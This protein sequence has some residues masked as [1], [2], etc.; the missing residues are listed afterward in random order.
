[1]DRDDEEQPDAAGTGP[2]LRG[3][4]DPGRAAE[5]ARYIADVFAD[6]HRAL[7]GFLSRL[8]R[9]DDDVADTVQDV[10][11][12]IAQIPDPSRLDL[13]PRAYLF[14]AAE[15]LVIDRSRRDAFRR[16][17]AHDVLD[18]Q[19]LPHDGPSVENQVHW[20]LAM[21]RIERR[22]VDAGP[23]VAQVVELSCLQDLT[24]PEIA[25]QLGVTVRTIERCMQRARDVCEPFHLAA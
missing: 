20:R 6:H 3:L 17:G 25:E 1:M 10:F 16:T 14:R 5:R 24:H 7:R 12:R 15:R 8:L 19:E 4:D 21:H 9:N 18:D 11:L 13:N 22:L 2:A 23:R